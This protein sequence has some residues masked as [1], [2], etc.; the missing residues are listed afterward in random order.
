MYAIIQQNSSGSHAMAYAATDEDAARVK[1]SDSLLAGVR[2]QVTIDGQKRV[3]APIGEFFGSGLGENPVR[4]L[5]FAMDPDGWYSSWW[6]MPYAAGATVTLVQ[7][8][9]RTS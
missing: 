5:F 4:S 9:R 8:S 7:Q 3:D 6:P 2:V 1:P